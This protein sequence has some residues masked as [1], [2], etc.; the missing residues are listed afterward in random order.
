MDIQDKSKEELI[1]ELQK[2]L[3]ENKYLKVL[4]EKRSAEL[5]FAHQELLIKDAEKEKRAAELY[6]ANEELAFQDKEK[7]KRALELGIANEELV[8]QG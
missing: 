2:L 1:S 5:I 7:G 8:F 3:E 6:I 4:K